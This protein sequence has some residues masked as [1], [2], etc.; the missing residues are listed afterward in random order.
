MDEDRPEDLSMPQSSIRTLAS[1]SRAVIGSA[2]PTQAFPLV[3]TLLLRASVNGAFAAWLLA[4]PSVW[5]D[6]FQAGA[7]Y[8]LADGA[9]GLMT[10]VLL[11]RHKP[12][13]APPLLVSMTLADAVLRICAGVAIRALPGIPHSPITIVL[14][15]GALGAWA[16]SAGAIAMITWFVAHERDKHATLRSRS[17]THALFDP[18]AATGLVAF[19]LA[20]YALVEGPPATAE[21]LRIAAGAASSALALVF[22]VVS[23][24]VTRRRRPEGRTL[25]VTGQQ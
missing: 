2:S 10:V 13:S 24:S 23:F 14:F 6:I 1:E 15:F 12:I 3:A 19:M 18:L 17:R 8:A 11:M 16:A 5:I 21:A 22:L 7:T 9:L 25:G 4:R 20:A